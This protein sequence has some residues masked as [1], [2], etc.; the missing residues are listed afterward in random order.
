[1][2]PPRGPLGA[3]RR[4]AGRACSPPAPPNAEPRTSLTP[5]SPSRR[6]PTDDDPREPG[7][8][9]AGTRFPRA[10]RA[11]PRAPQRR[12]PPDGP[13]RH[14]YDGHRRRSRRLA[15]WLGIARR[16]ASGEELDEEVLRA[17]DIDFRH[18]GGILSP[19]G[20]LAR[21]ISVT[22]RVDAWGITYRWNGHHDEAVGRPLARATIDD[23]GRY[24]W[25]D[26]D[27]LDR[28]SLEEMAARARWLFEST[29]AWCA[30][31]TRTTACSS[32]VAGCADT[33]TSSSASP[34]S[35][36]SCGG[37]STS[38]RLPAAR[39]RTLLRRGRPVDPLHHEAVTTSARN[40]PVAVAVHVP[41]S[42]AALPA[43]THPSHRAVHRCSLLPP[44]LRCDQALIPDLIAAGV[45]ILNPIQ[46]RAA[47]MEPER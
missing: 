26:P 43:R 11:H 16:R 44:L 38:P 32:W 1:V 19:Q 31:G 24:P 29:P 47:G 40:R 28:A 30:P 34:V 39:R 6:I 25:P 5:S 8:P 23:L 20:P 17:L 37:S 9:Q 46:P 4:D 18:V 21:R 45:R 3:H 7:P 2:P 27:R 41:R 35:L 15:S 14:G 12:P 36:S 13:R 33:T 42:R 10:L 22:E